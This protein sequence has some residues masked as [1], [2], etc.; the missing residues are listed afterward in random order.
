MVGS[1]VYVRQFPVT[2]S[3][4]DGGDGRTV[5]GRIVPYGEVISFIDQYDGDR[6]KKERFVPGAFAKQSRAWNRVSL[7]F[8]HDNGFDNTIGYGR[9]LQEMDDGAYATFRLYEADAN[10]AREMM[11]NSHGGLSLEFESRKLDRMDDNGV[12]IRDNVHVRRVGITDD[13]AYLGA[14]ILAVRE[15]DLIA[16][17]PHL[18][19]IRADL[20]ARKALKL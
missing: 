19:Q 7:S 16:P 18:D 20:A 9:E 17:T 12:I 3:I 13:P 14:E 4:Q 11:A 15:R 5:Y 8:R 1:G 2:F 6:I 10:K